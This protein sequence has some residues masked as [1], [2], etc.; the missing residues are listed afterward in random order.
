MLASCCPAPDLEFS[1][2][3]VCSSVQCFEE[4]S[5]EEIL[6]EALEVVIEEEGK[7]MIINK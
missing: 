5:G 2:D 1:R 7:E 6:D 4:S 3:V